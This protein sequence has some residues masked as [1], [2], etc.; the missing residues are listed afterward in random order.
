[1]SGTFK[2]VGYQKNRLRSAYDD[3]KK[4]N[5]GQAWAESYF[6]PIDELEER[7]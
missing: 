3:F 6:V 4:Q 7:Y 1:M 2:P 5:P